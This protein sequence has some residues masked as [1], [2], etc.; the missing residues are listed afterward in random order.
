MVNGRA[1]AFLLA[2]LLAA[3]GTVLSGDRAPADAKL[4]EHPRFSIEVPP[5]V[6]TDVP[7]RRIVIRA[8]DAAG[9]PDPTYNEQPLITGIRLALPQSDDAKLGPFHNGVLELTTDAHESRKVYISEP[10]IVVDGGDRKSASLSVPRTFR[11]FALVPAAVALALCLWPR[12]FVLAMFVAIWS[13]LAIL[14]GGNLFNAFVQTIDSFVSFDGEQKGTLGGA[15]LSIL[16]VMLFFGSLF[17][18]LTAGGGLSALT[19]RLALRVDTRERGQV[20]MLLFGI[21]TFL[22]DY[23]HTLIVGKTL[24]PLSDRLKISREKFAFLVDTTAVPVVALAVVST[25]IA[26]ERG[27]LRAV[28]DELGIAGN[29]TAA[30]LASLPYC[31]YPILMLTF[32][33]LV[34]FLGHDFG[35]MLRAEG[36]AATQGHLS[37]PDL[38]DP[39]VLPPVEP[40]PPGGAKRVRNA[41]IPLGL[42][43]ALAGVGLWWTGRS[44]LLAQAGDRAGEPGLL[45]ALEHANATRVM[46][47]SAFLASVAAVALAVWS[48]SLSL[49][50]GLSAWVSGL[51]RMVPAALILVLSWSFQRV[52]DADHLNTAGFLAEIGQPRVTLEWVPLVAF[53][54]VGLMT[55]V[56][57]STWAALAMALPTYLSVTHALLVDLNEPDA[58]HPFFLA[59]IGAVIGGVVFGRHCSPISDTTIFA[60]ASSSCS[61]LDHVFT[62]LPYAL[63]VG[64]VVVLFGYAP[65]AYGYSPVALL[66]AATLVLILLLQFGGR[67][68]VPEE[69][70]AAATAAEKKADAAEPAEGKPAARGPDARQPAPAG[71]KG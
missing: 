40:D 45:D 31:F 22:D 71:A 3:P 70:A 4:V 49:Q 48:R 8:Y 15:H 7:V 24:R 60:S 64:G 52:C 38:S 55:A 50:Q 53:V 17:A 42:L 59:T 37:R 18:V 36:R 67:P 16:A 34:I 69:S 57:G 11:W 20:A 12:N 61:H 10:E 43:F 1:I 27:T 58:T 6:L 25:W 2:L 62:Q 63:C 23:A 41:L 35:P 66:P 47:F 5:I 28:F 14:D 68:A 46:L 29:P 56:L 9:N 54:T 21:F 19:D 44:E 30:L 65:V 33:A 13:G 32:A 51:Q 39:A 26:A